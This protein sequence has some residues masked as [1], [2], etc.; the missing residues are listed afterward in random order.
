MFKKIISLIAAASCVFTVSQTAFAWG[1]TVIDTSDAVQIYKAAEQDKD[2]P[3]IERTYYADRDKNKLDGKRLYGNFSEAYAPEPK[4]LLADFKDGG[5]YFVNGFTKNSKGKRY[6]TQG[7]RAYG[8]KKIGGY[9]YHFDIQSGYMDTGR[10]KIC[11]AVYTFDEK[12]RWTKR[13]S[14]SGL[15]PEDFS[16]KVTGAIQNGFDTAQKKLYY[17]W[18]ESGVAETDV[19]IPAADRQILWCMYLESGFEWGCKETFDYDYRFDF[20]I[21]FIPDED[22]LVFYS[23]PE[24]VRTLTVNAGGKTADIK[25]NTDTDQIAFLDEKAHRAWLLH[26]QYWEYYCGLEEKYPYI[27][28]EQICYLE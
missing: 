24:V 23:E 6:Y 19:K 1:R 5:A 15:A 17:G 28:E 14:K 26:K 22:Y 12:G 25:Y 13:V 2:N 8:W 18:T 16:L 3:E 20:Y 4:L 11:G 9:W 21:R 7:E 27:G 10:T